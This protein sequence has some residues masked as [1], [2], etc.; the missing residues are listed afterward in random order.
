MITVGTQA[1]VLTEI[2]LDTTKVVTTRYIASIKQA[3]IRLLL[4]VLTQVHLVKMIKE[5]NHLVIQVVQML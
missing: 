1:I 2:L 5:Q 3:I 4:D